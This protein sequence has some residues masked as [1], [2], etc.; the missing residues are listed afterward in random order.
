MKGFSLVL[1]LTATVALARLSGQ[2][3]IAPPQVG[4]VRDANSG[5]RPV[6]GLAANFILGDSVTDGVLSSAF[7]GSFGIVKTDASL[8]VLDRA[9][10]TVFRMDAEAGPALFAFSD[11]GVPA[12]VYV[13]QSQ[14]IFKWN[15]DRLEPALFTLDLCNGSVLSIASPA[16]DRAA[17]VVKRE[18]GL[19][20]VDLNLG[21]QTLLSGIDGPVLLRNNG[22]VLYTGPEGLVLRQADRSDLPIQGSVAVATFELMGKD[23][24][25]VTEREPSRHFAIRLDTG[26]EQMYQLPEA[27]P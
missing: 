3:V 11:D 9:G 8:R 26:R 12:F 5:L 25:H 27:Q 1:C 7:S 4:W 23:W 14:T 10:Q 15:R 13:A 22:A 20:L 17:A 19:W 24:V 18:D 21:T 2:P 6:T 16:R